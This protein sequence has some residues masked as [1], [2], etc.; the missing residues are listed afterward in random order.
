MAHN[1]F[2]LLKSKGK[3]ISLHKSKRIMAVFLKTEHLCC[4]KLIFFFFFISTEGKSQKLRVRHVKEIFIIL[5]SFIHKAIQ[6]AVHD[7]KRKDGFIKT[8][9]ET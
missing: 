5:A 9:K 8:L 3:K 1:L 2:L 7:I 4:K 6:S